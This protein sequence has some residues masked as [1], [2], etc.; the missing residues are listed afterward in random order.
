MHERKRF[1]FLSL[2][3]TIAMHRGR[4]L[5]IGMAVA[6]MLLAVRR[7][8]MRDLAVAFTMRKVVRVASLIAALSMSR[9]TRVVT[10]RAALT[11]LSRRVPN[12]IL[13]KIVDLFV[14]NEKK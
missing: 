3:A 5:V 12:G 6:V 13:G 4:A 11:A 10:G 8:R 9:H 7:N 14:F 1:F 2:I